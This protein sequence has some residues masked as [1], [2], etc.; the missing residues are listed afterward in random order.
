[1]Y[2]CIVGGSDYILVNQTLQFAPGQTQQSLI[3]QLVNDE[4]VEADEMFMLQLSSNN[5]R[6]LMLGRSN[7]SVTIGDDDSM[8]SIITLLILL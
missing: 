6:Q 4:R 8:F 1:M 2:N 7:V 3:V 5:P